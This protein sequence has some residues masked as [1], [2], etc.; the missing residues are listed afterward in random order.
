VRPAL[1]VLLCLPALPAGA[2]DLGREVFTSVAQPSCALCHT[3]A[4]AGT[5]GKL[6]PSLDELKPGKARALQA[7][8]NGVGVMPAYAGKL[9]PEEIE[10]VAAYVAANA[11]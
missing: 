3:L 11:G 8:R 7:V 10:A 2:G 1:L 9:T 4:A 5:K 6:G